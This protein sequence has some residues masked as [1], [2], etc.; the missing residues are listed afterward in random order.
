M[1]NLKRRFLFTALTMLCGWFNPVYSQEDYRTL[2]QQALVVDTHCDVLMQILR[3]QN[4]CKRSDWGHVDLVRLQAGQVDVQFFA[5]W[6]NPELYKPDKMY[7]QT[8]NLIALFNSTMSRCQGRIGLART[9]QEIMQLT[10]QGKIAACLAVEGGTAIEN[11]LDKLE[12]I[13][14]LGA[15]YLS[16]TW[17]DSPDWASSAQDE[18]S[19]TYQGVRGLSGFGRQ[20][21]Q[22]MNRLGM[23]IDLSHSGEQTFRDVMKITTQPVIASHSCV[24]ALAPHVRNLKDEQIIAISKNGGYIGINFYAGFLDLEFDKKY[25]SLRKAAAAHLDSVKAEFGQN[26]TGYCKYQE[27]YYLNL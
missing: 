1:K 12:K 2:H 22:T 24:Y 8:L 3:G 5:V 25:S 21:V 13:Y 17:N 4:F 10:G 23:L 20:V 6:P 7:D 19:E 14:E 15:R 16:L 18:A 11:N 27:K 26:Y 9:P